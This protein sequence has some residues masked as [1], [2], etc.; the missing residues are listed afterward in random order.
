MSELSA[1]SLKSA[2]E[3]AKPLAK[4]SASV[5]QQPQDRTVQ[6][7]HILVTTQDQATA[8]YMSVW[9]GHLAIVQRLIAAGADPDTARYVIPRPSNLNPRPQT[10]DPRPSISNPKP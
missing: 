7:S 1:R 4:L 10:L 2:R 6:T 8:L 9:K 5:R 3:T